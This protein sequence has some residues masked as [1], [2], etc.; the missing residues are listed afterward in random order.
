MLFSLLVFGLVLWFDLFDVLCVL[1]VVF[2]ACVFVA[3]TLHFVR[4]C[5]VCFRVGFGFKLLV[6]GCAL[7]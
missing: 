6:F 1:F 5:L 7:V 3:C 4:S 2:L